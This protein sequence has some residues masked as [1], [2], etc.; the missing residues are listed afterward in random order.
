M[1][2]LD[3]RTLAITR[4]RQEAREFFQ[5]VKKE[6]ASA[7]AIQAIEI[8]PEARAAEKFLKLLKEKEHEYCAFMSAQA[9]RVLFSRNKGRAVSALA[10]TQVIAV[11]PKTRQELEKHGVRVSMMPRRHSSIGLVELLSKKSP[12]GKKIIM[13]RSGEAGDYAAAALEKLGM[14][15]DEVFLYRARTAKVTPAWK[16]FYRMLMEDKVD[17]VIF[18]SASNVRSFFE[19]TNRLGRTRV[20]KLAQVISIG[21]FT[22]AELAKRKI[23]HR[24]A[25]DHTIRGTVQVARKLFRGRSG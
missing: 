4:S 14:E 3:G 16:K 8:V 25:S 5:L 2:G 10:A 18:T 22:S 12:K 20:D 13:P 11:G 7:M 24:Q 1:P 21:P 23:R 17:A 9:A 6:G 19:I 15:V